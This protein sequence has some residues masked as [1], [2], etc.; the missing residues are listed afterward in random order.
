MAQQLVPVPTLP[1]V[2][3]FPDYQAANE[4]PATQPREPFSVDPNEVDR[5][6]GAHA[7]TQNALAEW[8]RSKGMTPLRPGGSAADFDLGWDDGATFNVAEVKSLTRGNETGQL[9]LGLGQVLH[10]AML[11]GTNGRS[12]RPVLAI[13]GAPT[14]QRWIGLT[15]AHGV[16]LVW[17][18]EF[19]GLETRAVVEG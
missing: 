3:V 12:I 10:H 2:E 15:A 6:L 13:D 19:D 18:G 16:V 14:D 4:T 8:V 17:P 1:P 11:L 7:A 9:R 5:A